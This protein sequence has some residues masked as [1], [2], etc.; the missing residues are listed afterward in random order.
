MMTLGNQPLANSL[1]T[2]SQ[3]GEPEPTFPLELVLCQSCALLQITESVPPE[4]LFGEYLYFSSFSDTVLANARAL[5]DAVIARAKLGA[6]SLVVEIASNDG[7]LLRNYRQRDIPVL[8]IE[9]ASNI[10]RLANERGI[11]TRNEFFGDSCATRLRNE[12]L[13]ADAIHA[14]NVLAHV[15]DVNGVVEGIRILLADDGVAVI[16]TPYVKDMLDGREFDTI[17]HEHLCFYSLTALDHLFRRHALVIQDVQHIPIHGGSLRVFVMHDRP[18]HRPSV[19]VHSMLANERAWG[20]GQ[21]EVYERFRKS[22]RELGDA[23][24]ALLAGLKSEGRSIA[25]YGAAAKATV[26]FN[27]LGFGQDLIDFVADRSPYKQSKYMPGVHLPILAPDALLDRQPDYV[28]LNTWNFAS[29]ILEQ[30]AEYRRR[31]GKFIIP[32][33]ELKIV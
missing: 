21:I 11:P 14:N 13:R 24:T 33:P 28:L 16:E 22:T 12:G 2:E 30:Q 17:Y 1:L 6:R 27:Y 7:Y 10:A 20:V 23:L 32:M 18:A 4:Q 3:L 8:G 9:P 25:A 5:A 29:E 15:P 26:M 19:A 31:G